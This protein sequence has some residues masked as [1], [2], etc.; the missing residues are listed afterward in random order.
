MGSMRTVVAAAGG[1]MVVAACNLGTPAVR[2]PG[3]SEA[4]AVSDVDADGTSTSSPAAP[5]AG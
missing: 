1:L 4:V 3:P 2:H 5:E